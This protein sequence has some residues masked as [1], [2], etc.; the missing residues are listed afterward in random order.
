MSHDGATVPLRIYRKEGEQP[1]SVHVYFHGGGMILGSLDMYD[2]TIKNYVS[3]T[4]VP[5]VA[6]DYR[7]A[8]EHPFPAPVEDCYAAAKW[9]ADHVD[10]LGVD[11]ERIVIG[12]DSA[13]GNLAAAVALMSRDRGG[14]AL[15]AQMLI[16]P[17]LDDRNLE[18]DP[19]LGDMLTWS[20]ADHATGWSAYLGESFGTDGVSQYAAPTRAESL[21]GLPRAFLDVGGNDIFHDEDLDYATRLWRASVPTEVH[22]YPGGPHGYESLAAATHLAQRTLAARY[23][24]LR[25]V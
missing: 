15:A 7:L 5:I 12:G 2:V 19:G 14:P 11:P 17:M 4:G 8:P 9:T 25:S 16:Y 21:E 18:P 3:Q 13:G 20:Y 1:G 24:F 23:G 22:V 6:P 10:E